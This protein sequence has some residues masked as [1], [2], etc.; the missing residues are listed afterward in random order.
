VPAAV[1]A[2]NP[3]LGNAVFVDTPGTAGFTTPANASASWWHTFNERFSL[4]ADVGYTRWST[5]QDLVV[6]Y[7][8]PAQPN[9]VEAFDWQDTWFGSI[10]M[11]Y[12]FDPA[13]VLRA[14]VAVDG[15]PTQVATRTP[16]VP[17]GTRRWVTVGLGYAPSDTTSVDFG[18]GHIFV[19]DAEISTRTATGN[20]LAGSFESSGNLLGVSAQFK[21]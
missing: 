1:T 15:S 7:A 18:Y 11:E 16:R 10:G 12:R 20:R 8:N 6:D 21:F 4:G 17:D 2:L 13:W 3:A 5:F 19:N 9:T 14:G